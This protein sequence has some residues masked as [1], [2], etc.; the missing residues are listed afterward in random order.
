[1]P[2]RKQSTKDNQTVND[3]TIQGNALF[4]SDYLKLCNQAI[5]DGNIP[6]A[7]VRATQALGAGMDTVTY[8]LRSIKDEG[9][10]ITMPRGGWS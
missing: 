9:L 2:A 5:A 3:R 6:L 8:H 1:M 4:A 7:Q 10:R